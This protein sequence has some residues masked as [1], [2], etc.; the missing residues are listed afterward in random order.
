[1][2]INEIQSNTTPS[3]VVSKLNN[4]AENIISEPINN[5]QVTIETE[6]PQETI[7]P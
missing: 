6:R 2:D 1:M 4:T 3:I 7:V 5:V